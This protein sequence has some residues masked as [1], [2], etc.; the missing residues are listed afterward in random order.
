MK[1]KVFLICGRENLSAD[2]D[3][4]LNFISFLNEKGFQVIH[5][6]EFNGLGDQ[7]QHIPQSSLGKILNLGINHSK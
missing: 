3:F 7:S 5:E 4:L 1:Q 6:I 2:V